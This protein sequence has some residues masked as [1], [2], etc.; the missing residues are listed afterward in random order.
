MDPE[1]RSVVYDIRRKLRRGHSDDIF[2]QFLTLGGY[3]ALAALLMFALHLVMARLLGPE[4]YASYGTFVAVLFTL[5]FCLTSIHLVIIRF[6]SYHRSRFQYEQINYI[7]SRALKW[8]F[9]A[10]FASFILVLVFAEYISGFFHIQGVASTVMLGFVVWFT[11]LVPVFEGAFKGLE[12]F[13]ALGRFRLI[14]AT[15]RLVL[16][17]T[18]VLLGFSVGGALFGLAL[19]TFA[20]LMYCYRGIYQLQRLKSVKPSMEQ[21]RRFAVP[22]V[23][24][25]VSIA[26]LLNIDIILVK[27]YFPAAEAGVFAAASLI[28]KVPF[29]VSMVFVGV[30]F[31]K[32]TQLHADG[33]NSVPVLKNA[34]GV[35]VPLVAVFTLLSFFFSGIFFRVLFGPEYTIGPILGFYVFGMGCL[36]ITVILAIYLLAV[37]QDRISF[38][39]PLFFMLLLALLTQFHDTLF[40]V[41][42]VVMLVMA[43]VLAYALYIARNVLEFDYFL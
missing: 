24:T 17:T 19:G 9:F 30:M 29:L 25:M 4:Q 43:V 28:A 39:L 8:A 7:I 36:A 31:P 34:L 42:V 32:I 13:G 40:Q 1:R 10:G 41:M 27:H 33:K 38:M 26:L 20:A 21:I 37:R 2:S 5:L 6:V 23:V 12:D 11:M 22:V 3:S 35:V 18:L 16:A 15:L 14:E